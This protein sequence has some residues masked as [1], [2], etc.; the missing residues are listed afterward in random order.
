[1]L[2]Q[3]SDGHI[4]AF[5]REENGNGAPNAGIA[6]RDQR[7]LILQFFRTEVKRCIVER[8]RVERRFGPR[9][10]LML[11]GERRG[12][13]TSGLPLASPASVSALG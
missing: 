12:R 7:D 5:A 8:R 9:L 10:A 11:S 4:R 1:M 6:A 2:V 3:I 13:D